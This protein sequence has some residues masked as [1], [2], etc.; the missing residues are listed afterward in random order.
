MDIARRRR[1]T[2]PTG[3]AGPLLPKP[4]SNGTEHV[5]ARGDFAILVSGTS[6]FLLLFER[7][8]KSKNRLAHTKACLFLVVLSYHTMSLHTMS[9]HT[10]SLHTMSLNAMI[11]TGGEALPLGGRCRTETR[12]EKNEQGKAWRK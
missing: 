2:T 8:S 12:R 10:M 5:L 11:M 4:S 1:H 3:A 7:C 9:L 6:C